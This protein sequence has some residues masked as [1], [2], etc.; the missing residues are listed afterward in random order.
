M[1]TCK[2]VGRLQKVGCLQNGWSF[3][4]KIGLLQKQVERLQKIIVRRLQKGWVF[5]KK[6]VRAFEI[7]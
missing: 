2:K 5:V 1:Q 6:N 3:A 7:N 4:K